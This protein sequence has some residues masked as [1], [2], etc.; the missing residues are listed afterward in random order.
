MPLPPAHFLVAAGAADLVRTGSRIPPARAWLVGGLVGVLPDMDTGVGFLL[1]VG[2]AY[3]G[4]FTHTFLAILVFTAAAW[5]AAGPRWGAVVG[6]AYAS[7][8]FI[9]LLENRHASSVQ[10]WW[11]LSD[12][13][14]SSVAPLFPTVPWRQ[15]AGAEQAAASLLEPGVLPWFLAQTT[16]A[17]GI[18]LLCVAVGRLLGGSPTPAEARAPGS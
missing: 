18:F 2:N 9:D 13:R 8:L 11:P 12:E 5:L 16:V 15:G 1:G 10:P 3:H 4:I 6:S 14:I 17:V 7:H